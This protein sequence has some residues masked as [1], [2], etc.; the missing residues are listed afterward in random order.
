MIIWLSGRRNV[1]RSFL[2]YQGGLKLNPGGSSGYPGAGKMNPDGR[3]S[4]PGTPTPY[5]ISEKQLSGR[6]ARLSGRGKTQSGNRNLP[7]REGEKVIRTV[8]QVIRHCNYKDF[9]FRKVG[10]LF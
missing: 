7:I 8:H 3:K 9:I 10:I 6:I 5:P 1:S 2:C 4:Y